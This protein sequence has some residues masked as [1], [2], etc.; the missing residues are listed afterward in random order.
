MSA[1]TNFS[2]TSGGTTKFQDI[3]GRLDETATFLTTPTFTSIVTLTPVA[4]LPTGVATG[5]IAISGSNSNTK[6]Y[7][8]TGAGNISS[9]WVTASL[10]S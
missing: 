1:T 6:L 3:E 9:G 10:G 2:Y 5:S 8:F 4:T 7:I